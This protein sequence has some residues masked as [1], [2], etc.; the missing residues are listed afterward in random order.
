MSTTWPARQQA[1]LAPFMA[2]SPIDV[3]A[4]IGAWPFRSQ[5]RIDGVGLSAVAD[6]FAL[7]RLFVSHLDSVFGFDTRTGN[8][9]LLRA[10]EADA[11]LLRFV[12]VDPAEPGWRAELDWFVRE[13]VHG[14]RITPG[15]HG[16]R[17]TDPFVADLVSAAF[18]ARLPVHI[19]IRLEDDR[20][21]HPRYDVVAPTCAE[22]SDLLRIVPSEQMVLLSGLSIADWRTIAEHLGAARPSRLGVDLWF[23]NGP[24][25]AVATLCADGDSDVFCYGSALPVQTAY[26]T[27]AQL[28]A[29]DITKEQRA[30][31]CRGNALRLL[32]CDIGPAMDIVATNQT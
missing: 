3:T 10:T 23:V 11:R 16:Y 30:A 26:A 15:Y 21:R 1:L 25:A 12:V 14:I 13:G 20:V 7:E 29:A 8:E 31:L 17:L 6:G 28:G 24:L 27:A 32:G 19:C 4:F 2:A 22:V 9:E 5:A 18:A